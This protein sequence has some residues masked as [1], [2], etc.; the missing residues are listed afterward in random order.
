MAKTVTQ[1]YIRVERGKYQALKK[2]QERFGAFL[3]YFERVTTIKKARKEV[4]LGKTISQEEL[5]KK[6]GV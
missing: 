5:F 2:L 4:K 6:I 3:N 1:K